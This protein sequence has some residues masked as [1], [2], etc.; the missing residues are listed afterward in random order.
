[1]IEEEVEF[2]PNQTNRKPEEAGDARARD[3]RAEIP[4]DINDQSEIERAIFVPFRNEKSNKATSS[5][6]AHRAT[7]KRFGNDLEPA[8]QDEL[9]DC[10]PRAWFNSTSRGDMK[11]AA[12]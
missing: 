7:I 11:S 10:P 6:Q 4:P 3:F 8:L 9:I 2:S 1:M 5:I 12:S